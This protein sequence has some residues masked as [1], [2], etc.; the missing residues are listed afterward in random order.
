MSILTKEFMQL[1]EKKVVCW[2]RTEGARVCMRQ[3]ST[4]FENYIQINLAGFLQTKYKKYIVRIESHKD[5]T[6]DILIFDQHEAIKAALAI[7]VVRLGRNDKNGGGINMPGITG[8]RGDINKLR[9]QRF[10]EK[11]LLCIVYHYRAAANNWGNL[12][13]GLEA[14]KDYRDAI[15]C[16]IENVSECTD[17]LK[18]KYPAP[19]D[20]LFGNRKRNEAFKETEERFNLR[21]CVDTFV[22]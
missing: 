6:A 9:D 21:G 12:K 1:I 4:G 13:G 10:P 18:K 5:K 19:Q 20:N 22:F 15:M 16:A 8:E 3:G 11:A 14:D 17:S 2:M 7:K